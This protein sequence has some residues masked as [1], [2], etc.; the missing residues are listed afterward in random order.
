MPARFFNLMEMKLAGVI[1]DNYK[2][3]RWKAAI[4]KA[5]FEI[6]FI[7][8]AV[9]VKNST[10]IRVKLAADRMPELEKLLRRLEIQNASRN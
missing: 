9:I 4:E 7:G 2:T 10:I 8:P 6:D 3:K 5:G 1:C